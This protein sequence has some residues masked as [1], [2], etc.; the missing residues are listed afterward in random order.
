MTSHF[1]WLDA[2]EQQRR[3]M[4]EVI[5]LFRDEGTLDEIGIGT[6]RDT[7]ANTLFPG[8]SVVHTRL[9][10]ALFV[11]WLV[12]EAVRN[13][14]SSADAAARLRRL[15]IKLIE[16]LLAGTDGLA[17]AESSGVIGSRSREHL[18]RMPSA[19]YWGTLMTWGIRS[20]DESIDGFMRRSIG[21]RSAARSRPA[22]DDP[23]ARDTFNV[24]GFDAGLPTRPDDLL[25][26]TDFLLTSDETEYLAHRIRLS[27]AGTMFAWLVDHPPTKG[28]DYVWDVPGIDSA[29]APAAELVEHGRRFSALVDG[30]TLLYNLLLAEQSARPGL[31]DDYRDRLA[32]WSAALAAERVLDGWDQR[33]FWDVI[34]RHNPRVSERTRAF[35]DQWRAVVERAP[36]VADDRAARELI[37]FRE[38]QL[39][40]A[41]ARIGNR[42]A[43]DAWGGASGLGRLN[44]RWP[45]VQQMIFD[46]HPEVLD[47]RS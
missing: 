45:T 10:Y 33:A 5:A 38:R 25:I 31:A 7:I 8:L 3:T 13:A 16:S 18:Q 23:E 47:A 9:R 32:T 30:A 39:K 41:R 21:L 12:E 34:R 22:A 43:I 27:T 14:R 2:D 36:D 29:P 24:S 28:V 26:R 35:V 15:E 37:R 42:A 6:V 44:Y 20:W 46:L 1:G 11:P 4:M 17:D 40:G 19:I